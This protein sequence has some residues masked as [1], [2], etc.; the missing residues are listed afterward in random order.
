MNT[1]I[2]KVDQLK[3]KLE[4][5]CFLQLHEM[6]CDLMRDNVKSVKLYARAKL[7]TEGLFKDGSDCY[8]YNIIAKL[9]ERAK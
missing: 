2:F 1:L 6:C 7:L 3:K 5:V 8:N 9:H 4:I